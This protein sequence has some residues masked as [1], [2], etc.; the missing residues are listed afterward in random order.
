ML[1]LTRRTGEA[2]IIN[3]EI[4]VRVI[5]LR[6]KAVKLGFTFPAGCSVLREEVFLQVRA[7]NEAAARALETL[8]D[9]APTSEPETER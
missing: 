6:G 1:Y 2:V 5:E 9:G 7:E 8:Q 3:S 4:E